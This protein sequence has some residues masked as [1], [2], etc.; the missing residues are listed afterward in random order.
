MQFLPQGK[1]LSLLKSSRDLNEVQ[2]YDFQVSI[3][4]IVVLWKE[5]KGKNGNQRQVTGDKKR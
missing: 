1:P 3:F 5:S 2:M 4:S